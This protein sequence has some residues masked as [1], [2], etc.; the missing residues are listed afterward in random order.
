MLTVQNL[1][2]QEAPLEIPTAPSKLDRTRQ[3]A[4]Q[5]SGLLRYVGIAALFLI[6]YFLIL[7]PVKK[8][9]LL[10][11]RELPARMA[12]KAREFSAQGTSVVAEIE[13]PEGTEQSKRTAALKKQAHRKS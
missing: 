9:A 8:Q 12:T 11:F 1:T 2:F 4:V 10:A 13:L 6:V 5:W 7:R 3:M